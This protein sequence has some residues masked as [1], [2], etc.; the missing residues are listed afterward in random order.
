MDPS[1]S[2]VALG[3]QIMFSMTQSAV[4]KDFV[5]TEQRT[6]QL[7]LFLDAF[8]EISAKCVINPK[9]WRLLMVLLALGLEEANRLLH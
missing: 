8:M 1:M 4:Y 2:D 9:Y 6:S 3:T 7:T 5:D